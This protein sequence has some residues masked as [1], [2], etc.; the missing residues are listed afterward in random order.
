MMPRSRGGTQR[1]AEDLVELGVE[2]LGARGDGIAVHGGEPIFLPFT[3]PGDRVRT[4]L[5]ARRRGGRE[6]RV[7][8]WLDSGKGR[9]TPPCPHFGRCGGCALQH[10]DLASY[11]AFKL[12]VLPPL[13]NG[14]A[15][16]P[17]WCSR[18]GPYRRCGDVR[19]WG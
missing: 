2:R 7:V 11:R 5:G 8:E 19:S 16:I 13:S 6:G 17:A 12:G 14:S 9:A 15:S 18:C 3:V 1:G 10:L 4:R